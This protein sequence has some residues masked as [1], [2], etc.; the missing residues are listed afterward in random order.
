MAVGEGFLLLFLFDLG[1]WLR[2]IAAGEPL[3]WKDFRA[4]ESALVEKGMQ[5]PLFYNSFIWGFAPYTLVH[6]V[7]HA[8]VLE[9]L[10]L[11]DHLA[12]EAP[13]NF[14]KLI[15]VAQF[16]YLAIYYATGDVAA[17]CALRWL[18]ELLTVIAVRMPPPGAREAPRQKAKTN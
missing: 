9:P 11:P 4:G 7:L 16:S 3:N 10:I 12:L 2:P 13:N 1:R 17:Y 6:A 5:H 8:Y 18:G 14:M 15:V